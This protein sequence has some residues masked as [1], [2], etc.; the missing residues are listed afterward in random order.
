MRVLIA[1]ASGVIGRQLIPMLLDEGHDVVGLARAAFASS[2][3][4]VQADALDL[5]AVVRIVSEA[6][7]TSSSTC[8]RRSRDN[9]IRSGSPNSS[10]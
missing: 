3:R 2:A 6:G 7:P 1:G 10:N 8:S 4:V 9:W 5:D